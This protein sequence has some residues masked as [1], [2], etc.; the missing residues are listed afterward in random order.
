VDG[1]PVAAS[2]WYETLREEGFV[3]GYRG[4]VLRRDRAGAMIA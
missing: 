4:L 1:E 3:Q 2:A